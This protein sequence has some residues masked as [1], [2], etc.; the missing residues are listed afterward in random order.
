[1][2][3]RPPRSPRTDT[4]FPS[5]TF[6]RSSCGVA[7]SRGSADLVPLFESF[8]KQ[9]PPGEIVSLPES[10]ERGLPRLLMVDS[11]P[12]GHVSAT[13]QLNK[14]FLDGWPDKSFL[15]VCLKGD[16][17]PFLHARHSVVRNRGA[18]CAIDRHVR[19]CVVF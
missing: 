17:P 13:G 6:C 2:I 7:A 8:R 4:L 15:Q 5:T 11:T 12:L 18:H 16:Y 10:R 1:M 14:T 3:R 9:A 19:A